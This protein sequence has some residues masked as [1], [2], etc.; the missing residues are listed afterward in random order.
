MFKKILF[1]LF[2]VFFVHFVAIASVVKSADSQPCC[3]IN[4]G[5][6]I[7]S[8]V[9]VQGQYYLLD[10]YYMKMSI[11]FAAETLIQFQHNFV[12]S[13]F[14]SENNSY[15]SYIMRMMNDSIA[16]DGRF[17]WSTNLYDGPYIELGWRV[18]AWG[19]SV[20]LEASELQKLFNYSAKVKVV[21]NNLSLMKT[22]YP[23][24]MVFNYGPI[25]HI[26][27][28]TTLPNQFFFN[29]EF[30]IYKPIFGLINI[31]KI[32]DSQLPPKRTVDRVHH[33]IRNS[34]WMVSVG[35]WLGFL[36]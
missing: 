25:F 16:L 24:D 30:N 34:V 27:Y 11:G 3:K 14:S 29:M 35:L 20:N 12:P 4:I 6:D 21:D 2:F 19:H 36:F 15:R 10:R 32:T 33:A 5:V 31:N 17:G 7:P 8:Y 13:G 26:G 23:T 28:S 18:M 1:F 9:G 22:V